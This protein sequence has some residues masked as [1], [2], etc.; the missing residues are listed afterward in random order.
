MLFE[1]RN[2]SDWSAE[3]RIILEH[4]GFTSARFISLDE[5]QNILTSRK[6]GKASVMTA[7]ALGVDALAGVDLNKPLLYSDFDW[8]RFAR[9]V[10]WD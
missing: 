7:H 6:S 10:F 1:A 4:L 8:R 2:Q 5:V 3:L 9:T